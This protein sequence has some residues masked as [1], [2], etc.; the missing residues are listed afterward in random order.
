VQIAEHLQVEAVEQRPVI[1][2]GNVAEKEAIIVDGEAITRHA[3]SVPNDPHAVLAPIAVRFHDG[4]QIRL[5]LAQ[6]NV[7]L[8]LTSLATAR[9]SIDGHTVAAA[10]GA[11]DANDQ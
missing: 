8:E 11:G 9:H 4:N 2:L 1:L 7:G 6:G 3:V 5:L 10:G